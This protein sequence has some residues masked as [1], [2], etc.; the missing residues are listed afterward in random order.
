MYYKSKFPKFLRRK[1]E[2]EAFV[3]QVIKVSSKTKNI[4]YSCAA[5]SWSHLI[6]YA[7]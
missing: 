7:Y 6:L 5:Y 4:G 3:V 1:N 2:N